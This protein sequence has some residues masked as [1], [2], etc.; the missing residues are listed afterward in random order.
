ML[1]IRDTFVI[2][3]VMIGLPCSVIPNQTKGLVC[4]VV[5]FAFLPID[6][7]TLNTFVFTVLLVAGRMFSPFCFWPPLL[8]VGLGYV[9]D[10]F[11]FLFIVAAAACN[12]AS[13]IVITC[14]AWLE[15]PVQRA[16]YVL[17]AL[18]PCGH[19]TVPF[20]LCVLPFTA[21]FVDRFLRPRLDG[22]DQDQKKNAEE[23]EKQ[24]LFVHV[25]TSFDYMGDDRFTDAPINLIMVLPLGTDGDFSAFSS[26]PG[27]KS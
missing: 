5:T 24:F 3:A 23:S 19:C 11:F 14:K 9:R 20:L 27:A 15:I 8:T 25:D 1:F 7:A 4:I 17:L 21:A 13:V 2:F 18:F 26:P 10:A 12:S 16:L 22:N 6:A